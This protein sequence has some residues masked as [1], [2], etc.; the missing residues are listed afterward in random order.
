M[1][2]GGAGGIGVVT[3]RLFLE[4]GY[5]VALVDLDTTA[6]E[7]A[8]ASIDPGGGR[9]RGYGADV[10]DRGSVDAMVG[11]VAGDLGGISVLVNNA[12]TT[13]PAP[14]QEETD[15]EWDRLLQ[16]HLGGAF[17]CAR[18]AYPHLSAATGA[19]IV[20]I[21][22]IAAR[23]GMPMRASYCAAKAGVE[24]LTRA[25]AVEW[26]PVGIRVN[27]VGPGYTRTPMM[28]NSIRQG[29]ADEEQLSA[30]SALGRVGE[31]E[32]VA[33]AVVF[34]ATPA[35]GYITGQ[36]LFVDGGTTIDGR[37]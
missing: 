35:A 31:P 26:A 12:G 33:A 22:S 6:A 36:T 30:T 8:A 13:H 21:A 10:T 37:W 18:A 17:R 32:E 20:N 14:T 15:E 34:L 24:G 5:C 23:L 11:A 29:R 9:A 16:V 1:I 4:A 7:A 19:S 27:A 2:T 3:G 28:M 25:L